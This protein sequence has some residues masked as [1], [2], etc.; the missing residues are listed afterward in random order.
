LLGAAALGLSGAAAR[1]YQLWRAR[2]G[3]TGSKLPVADAAVVPALYTHRLA[4]TLPLD[5]RRPRALALDSADRLYVAGDQVVRVYAAGDSAGRP[6]AE[7]NPRGVPSCLAMG[8]DGR[9]YVGVAGRVLAF[10]PSGAQVAAWSAPESDAVL[11][12]VAVAPNAIYAADFANARVWRMEITGGHAD[13]IGAPA[14]DASDRGFVV[15]SP[16]FSVAVDAD[17][18]VWVTNPGRHRVEH[19]SPAGTYLGSWGARGE[20]VAKFCGCCNPGFVACWRPA[21]GEGGFLTSEKGIPRVKLYDRAGGL[22][23]VVAGPAQFSLQAQGLALAADAQ[24]RVWVL[25]P[26]A[27]AVLRFEPT[28]A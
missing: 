16:F 4:G 24:G 2:A 10:D 1:A 18:S 7:I 12:S 9:L 3:A 5:L 21:Q 19:Y 20:A 11:T 17:A 25:D 6:L 8:P 22:R 27:H 13:A 14:R 23:G 28:D 26:R 15:P